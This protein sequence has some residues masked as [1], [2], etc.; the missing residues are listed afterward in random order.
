MIS[1][2]VNLWKVKLF[3]FSTVGVRFQQIFDPFMIQK[4]TF[5]ARF[6]FTNVILLLFENVF[7][8]IRLIFRDIF[9]YKH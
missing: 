9:V 7:G 8:I 3:S 1:I 4:K 5:S 6:I 2:L